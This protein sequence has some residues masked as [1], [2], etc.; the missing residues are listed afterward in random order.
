MSTEVL[1]ASATDVQQASASAPA[2]SAT[3]ESESPW[4]VT[5]TNGKIL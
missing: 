1:A 2:Q 4:H 3:A 5:S